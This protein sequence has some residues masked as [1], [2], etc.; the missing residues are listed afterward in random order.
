LA[1]PGIVLDDVACT[2]K[3]MPE[4]P[5]L[6]RELAEGPLTPSSVGAVV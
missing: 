3:T 2:S 4:F 1:V 5:T 6:W